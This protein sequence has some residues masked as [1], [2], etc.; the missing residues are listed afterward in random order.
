MNCTQA[1]RAKIPAGFSF[2]LIFKLKNPL[3]IYMRNQAVTHTNNKRSILILRN[4]V[5]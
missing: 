1:S 5:D 3:N 2:S 4:K